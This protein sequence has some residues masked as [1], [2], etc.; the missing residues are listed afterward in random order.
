M[1]EFY[2]VLDSQ[3]LKLQNDQEMKLQRTSKLRKIS[4][5]MIKAKIKSVYHEQSPALA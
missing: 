2:D 3:I 5:D 1:R 4:F